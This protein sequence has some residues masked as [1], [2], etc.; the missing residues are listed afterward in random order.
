MIKKKAICMKKQ[1][2]VAMVLETVI[3]GEVIS[4][5][6]EN[7]A[8]KYI[9][10]KEDID[11]YHKIAVAAFKRGD[12]VYKYGEVIG[13]AVKSIKPGEHVHVHNIQGVAIDDVN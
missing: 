6:S 4:I 5:M 12:I 7:E 10:A 8:I 2:N 9:V 13:K 3:A 1:D 11:K